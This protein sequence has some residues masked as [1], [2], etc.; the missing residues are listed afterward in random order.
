VSKAEKLQLEIELNN[1]RLEFSRATSQ[2]EQ[3]IAGL[4]TFLGIALPDTDAEFE[5][6]ENMELEGVDIASIISTSKKYRPEIIAY[7]KEK[8]M[9]DR[10]LAQ[11]KA[12]YGMQANLIAS[13]GLARG[14]ELLR[15]VYT[16]PFD[17]QQ[18][19][20]TLSI[21]ILDWGKKE[22]ITG[23]IKLQQEALDAAYN[24][25]ILEL[26]NGLEQRAMIFSR[27]VNELKILEQIMTKA[28]ERFEIS[29]KRY[30]LGNIDIT[31]LTLAQREKDQTKRDFINALKSYWV[32]YYEIRALSG[33]DVLNKKEINY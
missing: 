3:T 27:L 17:E 18:F 6:P 16:D 19:N 5:V 1:A 2:V 22:A 20:I 10:D 21:P 32:G 4:Y 14:S 7:Q 12:D 33:Y 23:R 24:Q 28:E 25:Q 9:S 31:N 13:I 11:A 26:E 30:V 29:N 15:E 8:A